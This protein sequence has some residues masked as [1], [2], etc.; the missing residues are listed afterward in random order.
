MIGLPFILDFFAEQKRQK[1]MEEKF[2]EFV[3]SL[4][5][6]VK[7]GVSI[8]RAI[9]HAAGTQYGSLTPY[10]R[11]L[12]RQIEWGYPLHDALTVFV[13]ETNNDVIRRS[14]A[15]VMQAEKSGGDMGSVLESVTNSVLE[16]KRIKEERKAQAYNQ[17]IQGYI[18]YFVFIIIMMVLQLYLIPKLGDIGG[19]VMSGLS[20]AGV[21]SSLAASAATAD[22]GPIFL[23]T[24]IIQGLFAGVMIGKF[25]E[26]S[27]KAGLRHSLIMVLAGYLIMNTATGIFGGAAALFLLVPRRWFREQ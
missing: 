7:S 16:T 15:I 25:S 20:G 13:K 4:V 27:F 21:S 8:P 24:I 11:K 18:I 6:S 17:I 3:R 19:E 23:A 26:G 12:S 9:Q 22:L 10:V 2:L 5:E 1:E 14:V